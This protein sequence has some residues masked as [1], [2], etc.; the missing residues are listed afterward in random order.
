MI[1]PFD[2]DCSIV[3]CIWMGGGDV[4]AAVERYHK[5]DRTGCGNYRGISLVAHAGKVLLKIID[6]ASV[7]NV[8]A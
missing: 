6:R 4:T 3:F 5:K 2:G 1:S 8:S 7:G